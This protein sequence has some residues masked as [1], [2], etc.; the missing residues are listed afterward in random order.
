LEKESAISKEKIGTLE[1]KKTEIETKYAKEV[2]DL[3]HQLEIIKEQE[4]HGV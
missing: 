4:G 1:S 3:A 2:K